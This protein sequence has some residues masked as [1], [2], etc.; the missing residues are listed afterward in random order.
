MLSSAIGVPATRQRLEKC[1]AIR[2]GQSGCAVD[3]SRRRA[4]GAAPLLPARAAARQRPD[5]SAGKDRRGR[6]TQARRAA[7]RGKS[8]RKRKHGCACGRSFAKRH[9]RQWKPAPGGG[10]QRLRGRDGVGRPGTSRGL[11]L[12][13]PPKEGKTLPERALADNPNPTAPNRS[14]ILRTQ[15]PARKKV[16]ASRIPTLLLSRS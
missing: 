3:R 1:R 14:E 4:Q 12:L 11:S 10:Q 6:Q 2:L 9:T 16:F 13:R 15:L 5:H 7:G 8:S